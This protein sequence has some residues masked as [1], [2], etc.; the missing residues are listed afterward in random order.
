MW[1]I[2]HVP[3]LEEL[4]GLTVYILPNSYHLTTRHKYVR[5]YVPIHLVVFLCVR[6]T[7]SVDCGLLS[8]PLLL[9]P[10]DLTQTPSNVNL[11]LYMI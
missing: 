10:S 2:R 9:L 4:S 6:I 8:L 7:F 11:I 1:H 5:G 3:R